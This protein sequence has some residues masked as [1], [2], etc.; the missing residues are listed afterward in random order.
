MPDMLRNG[1][2]TS[3]AGSE[4]EWREVI[5]VDIDHRHGA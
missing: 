4:G 2:E 5:G 1:Q 3:V